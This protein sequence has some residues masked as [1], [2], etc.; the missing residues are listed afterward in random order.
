MGTIVVPISRNVIRPH[1]AERLSDFVH[2]LNIQHNNI[3]FAME[4]KKRWSLAILWYKHFPTNRWLLRSPHLIRQPWG[5]RKPEAFLPFIQN[6]SNR[7]SRV[8]LTNIKTADIH[9]GNSPGCFVSS[10]TMRIFNS[11]TH[12]STGS[13]ENE[14]GCTWNVQHVRSIKNYKEHD[15]CTWLYKAVNRFGG[16]QSSRPSGRAN[17]KILARKPRRRDRMTV[18]KIELHHNI[19]QG[20]EFLLNTS[21]TGP[22]LSLQ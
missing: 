13:P 1:G 15:R 3:D 4:T 5:R 2:C 9:S 11:G 7:I 12:L 17:P 20:D 10:K 22:I 21:W 19:N 18:K 8:L 6:T 14:A 16:T